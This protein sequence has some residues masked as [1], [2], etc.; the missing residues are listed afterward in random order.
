MPSKSTQESYAVRFSLAILLQPGKYCADNFLASIPALM[1]LITK[2]TGVQS[3]SLLPVSARSHGHTATGP[4]SFRS[5]KP[6]TSVKLDTWHYVYESKEPGMEG[7]SLDNQAIM[8]VPETYKIVRGTEGVVQ[9]LPFKTDMAFY[10][11]LPV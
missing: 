1:P 2:T 6:F 3:R 7:L 5:H 4:T 10:S 11:G 9:A 8:V